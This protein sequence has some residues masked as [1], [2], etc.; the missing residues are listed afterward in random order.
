MPKV[1][2]RRRPGAGR[3]KADNLLAGLIDLET[4]MPAEIVPNGY[5]S[6]KAAAA[7]LKVPIEVIRQARNSGC[8]AFTG[9]GSINRE[10]LLTWL[11]ANYFNQKQPPETGTEETPP[12][13][14]EDFQDNYNP[15]DET[16]GVGQTLKSLQAYERRAKRILDE[17]E[18]STKYHPAV[19]AEKAKEARDSWLKV[20]NS[21]LKYDLAVDLAKRE[22]GELL[23]L[24]D[25]A[26]GVQALLAWHT[27]A[28]SDALRNAIPECEGKNKYDIAELLDK[29]LRSSIYRN[30]KLGMKLGK[31]P[32]W[33]GKTAIE[34]VQNEGK[35]AS[36]DLNDY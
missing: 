9:S 35:K 24:A 21:L 34:H 15:P 33:M 3:K 27:V 18:K 11:N 4:G 26:K 13:G 19:K 31:I 5:A 22:S 8:P 1:T 30:F 16:G 28:T 12:T 17:I 36:T 6:A 2:K 25:A 14:D 32:E 7:L 29:A 20:V 23:P 10:K